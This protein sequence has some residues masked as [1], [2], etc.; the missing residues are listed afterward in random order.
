MAR[1]N[2]LRPTRLHRQP[3]RAAPLRRPEPRLDLKAE[4]KLKGLSITAAR[5]ELLKVLQKSRRPL[6][7][8]D[9][10][11]KLK[12]QAPDPATLYRNV[13]QLEKAGLITS[14]E[15]ADRITRYEF[16][17]AKA[18]HHHHISCTRCKKIECV[19]VCV[20]P[21]LIE[22]VRAL[23]FSQVAHQLSFQAICKD[24]SA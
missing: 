21:S 22:Q 17:A 24:C 18:H 14:V 1:S 19:A 20:P 16:A 9:I 6:S 2:P 13:L 23:G 7:I 12:T 15:L 4:L 5:V 8:A 10:S 11:Q 3:L